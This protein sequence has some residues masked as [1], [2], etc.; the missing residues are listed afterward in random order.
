MDNYDALKSDIEKNINEMVNDLDLNVESNN[1]MKSRFIEW[2]FKNQFEQKTINNYTNAISIVSREAKNEKLVNKSIYDIDNL[3][4]LDELLDKL[5]QNQTYIERK[6]ASHNT[7]SAALN[8]YRRFIEEINNKIDDNME[9]DVVEHFKYYFHY[10]VEKELDENDLED[11]KKV[12][13][14]YN[15]EYSIE[16]L[17]KLSLNE[18]IYDGKDGNTF[19]SKLANQYSG[20]GPS[21]RSGSINMK[22]GIY[23]KDNQYINYKQKDNIIINPDSYFNNLKSELIEVL[24][25]ISDGNQDIDYE[26]YNYLNGMWN[27]ILKIAYFIRP[28]NNITFGSESILLDIC[29]YFGISV[30]KNENTV[31]WSYRIKKYIN[32]NIPES[33]KYHSTIVSAIL[34]DYY[35]KYIKK[36]SNTRNIEKENT[37]QLVNS[38]ESINMIY[39]GGPGCG[40]SQTVKRKYC[41]D[42]NAY[43][44]TTFYPDYTNSD[45]IGQLIPKY[46]KENDKLIYD[47]QAGPFTKAL[48]L[49]YRYENRNK[50]V[51]LIIEEINRGNAAAIFGDIFQLLD[52]NANG[53]SEYQ[54]SNYIIE[55]YLKEKLGLNLENRIV[56]PANLSIIATMNTSDQNVYTLDSAFKRRWKMKYISN[57]FGIDEESKDY[58]NKI[59]EMNV[60]I[61]NLNITWKD[62]NKKINAAI[63]DQNAFGINSE[64]KQLGKYFVGI[65]DLISS[66][67]YK[68][69]DFDTASKMFAEKVLVYLW[70]DIAKLK[71]SD[72]FK[73]DI[74]TFEKLLK[75]Y[76]VTG[77]DVFS[78]NVKRKLADGN[79]E[80]KPENV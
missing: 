63:I 28:E 49:A 45:F 25:N 55:K 67:V 44:R 51:Y 69:D 76:Q 71:P 60:P 78:E 32:D 77:I 33:N 19:C 59:G 30:K 2:M 29:K 16:N 31:N 11:E 38:F 54:I 62:F 56:I 7:N 43:I 50:D 68:T 14:K 9:I 57:E 23:I 46:D 4:E 47:I 66:E 64:D 41:V 15:S 36:N 53:E 72:W 80:S 52:R 24:S 21:I 20:Y 79:S 3:K 61:K 8:Q 17:K 26:K 65:S 35:N 12:I 1:I 70:E 10:N 6:I 34:W 27:V 22:F 48:E 5:N 39:Y 37:E 58:D 13:N 73:E 75:D 74:R 18:Y 42:E 40:K